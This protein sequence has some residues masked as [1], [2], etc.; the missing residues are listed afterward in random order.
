MLLAP[1]PHDPDLPERGP[2]SLKACH[3]RQ[4]ATGH[5][6]TGLDAAVRNVCNRLAAVR[7]A[8]RHTAAA[9]ASDRRAFLDLS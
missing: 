8:L 3:S 1:H 6:G 5:R 7:H 4:W 9:L 2:V